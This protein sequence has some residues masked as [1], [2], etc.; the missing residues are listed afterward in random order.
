MKI[1]NITDESFKPYGRVLNGDFDVT[2]LILALNRTK[3][4]DDSVVYEPSVKEFEALPAGKIIKDSFFGGLPI[5][6]GYCNGTNHKLNAV[7]YHRSS[8][9]GISST[10]LILLLGKQQDITECFQYDSSLIEAF[11]V[12]EGTVYEIYSTTLH[13]APCSV[14]GKPY[15]NIIALPKDT[16]TSFTE[17][18]IRTEEDKLMTA[19]NKWLIAHKD[20]DIA[21]AFAG[22]YG[23]NITI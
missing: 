6:I 13:F 20:A 22:I 9:L 21:G 2:E 19:K 3:A 17:H 8:E 18:V 4:P 15:R 11:Y 23:D 7:E 1:N 10:P 16:N 12:P 14:D 5:Q